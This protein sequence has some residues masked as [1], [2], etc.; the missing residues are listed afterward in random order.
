MPVTI[1]IEMHARLISTASI[2]MVGS[3]TRQF[4]LNLP[5]KPKRVLLNANDD[6]LASESTVKET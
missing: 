6:V 1:Y 2:P 4:K 5:K 3:S